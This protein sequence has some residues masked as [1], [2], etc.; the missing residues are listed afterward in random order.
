MLKLGKK[1]EYAVMALVHMDGL[2]AGQLATSKVISEECRI[3]GDLL[4]KVLQK[5][6]RHELISSVHG[7]KGG[8]H[9]SR[10]L[11]QI[12]LGAVIEAL[13]GPVQLSCCQES[14]ESCEQYGSCRIRSS[15]LKVQADLNEYINGIPVST[16]RPQ[17]FDTIKIEAAAS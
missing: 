10:N 1:V 12:P 3:P 13:E 5:L 11:E 2:G 8:Y 7:S 9:L 14:P 4:G 16:F 15:I 17:D 6:A